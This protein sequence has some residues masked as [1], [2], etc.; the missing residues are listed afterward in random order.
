MAI[1]LRKLLFMQ[2]AQNE[3]NQ[4]NLLSTNQ[5]QS[6]L[7]GSLMGDP[8][9]RLLIGANILGAGVKGS[10]PFS[11]ITP[12]VLQT[13]QIQKALRP[14]RSK[15]FKVTDKT[16]GREVLITNEE[17]ANNPDKYDPPKPTKM[18]ESEEDKYTGKFFGKEFETINNNATKAFEN[19]ANLDLMNQL[20]SLPN[21]KTGF[22]GQLRTEVASLAKEFGVDTDIQD[23]TAAEALKGISGKIVLDGL[24]N[25]KGAI[26]D[27]ERAFLVSITPGL[28]NSIEGNKLLISIAKRQNQLVTSLAEE[29]NQWQKDNGGLSKKNAQGLTW[30]QYK[31]QWQKN[32]PVLQPKLKNQIQT[33]SK[34]VDPDFQD[35]IIIK[36]GKRYMLIG[37]NYYELK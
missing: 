30:G 22:A 7:L 17:Y 35:N 5:A 37:G 31:T 6:G 18:F 15:P 27:G 14:K 9:A 11:A 28:T 24:S 2:Q 25:F 8:T 21:I 16:T 13:A 23:L 3:Q 4:N 34:K 36:D 20:I 10:D 12:A 29:A 32:N 1:D 26:S 33:L 19:N